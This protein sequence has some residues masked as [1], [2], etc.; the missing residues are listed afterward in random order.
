MNKTKKILSIYISLPKWYKYYINKIIMFNQSSPVIE[1]WSYFSL[2]T[3]KH[4]AM[5]KVLESINFCIF[6]RHYLALFLSEQF[7]HLVSYFKWVSSQHDYDVDLFNH[8]P[9]VSIFH[10]PSK[11]CILCGLFCF[12]FPYYYYGHFYFKLFDVLLVLTLRGITLG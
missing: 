7:L 4:L 6:I 10:F 2:I 12:F 3:L 8:V 9:R 5:F 11:G 1:L